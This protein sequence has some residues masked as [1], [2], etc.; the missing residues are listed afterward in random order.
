M[1]TTFRLLATRLDSQHLASNSSDSNF[2]IEK[3]QAP[4][5]STL[6]RAPI[7]VEW[8]GD[9]FW[10][11]RPL[12]RNGMLFQTSHDWSGWQWLKTCNIDILKWQSYHFWAF[13]FWKYGCM[14]QGFKNMERTIC[15]NQLQWNQLQRETLPSFH[16]CET[17]PMKTFHTFSLQIHILIPDLYY[18]A[19]NTFKHESLKKTSTHDH[20]T[21]SKTH[22]VYTGEKPWRDAPVRLLTFFIGLTFQ[23]LQQISKP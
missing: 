6:L 2:S 1:P 8:N 22:S 3:N 4:W 12:G 13:F 16:G 10:F 14:M 7:P 17:K 15:R 9:P 18:K 19:S 21:F 11:F 23:T 20:S 5:L